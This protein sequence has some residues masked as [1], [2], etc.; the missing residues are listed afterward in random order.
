MDNVAGHA[1]TQQKIKLEQYDW[2]QYAATFARMKGMKSV[3]QLLQDVQVR[4]VGC[5]H[6]LPLTAASP[7]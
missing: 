4:R 2:Q 5:M 7:A 1:A 6:T 3:I